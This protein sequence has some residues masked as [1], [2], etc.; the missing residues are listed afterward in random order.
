MY[1]IRV[2]RAVG[3]RY[4]TARKKRLDA[5]DG[6][7]CWWCGHPGADS[8]DHVESRAVNPWRDVADITN[9]EPIHGVHGCPYCP[10]VKGK[11]RKCNQERGDGL[12]ARSRATHRSDW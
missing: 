1:G 11:R 6:N 5:P 8:V 9:L 3:H 10:R 2:P 12:V 4:R 7:I